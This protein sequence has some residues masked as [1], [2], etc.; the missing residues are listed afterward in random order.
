MNHLPPE[1]ATALQL[2]EQEQEFVLAAL[3]NAQ[4]SQ[5]WGR[6]QEWSRKRDQVSNVLNNLKAFYEDDN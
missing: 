2:L 3:K 4:D 1:I 6:A 5:D